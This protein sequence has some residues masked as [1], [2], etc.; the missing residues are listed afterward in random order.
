MNGR[1]GIWLKIYRLLFSV[2]YFV[3]S[4][5]QIQMQIDIGREVY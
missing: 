5:D 2:K 4:H 1:K 3:A